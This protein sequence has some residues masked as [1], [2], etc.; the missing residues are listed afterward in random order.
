MSLPNIK[1]PCA[2]CPFRKDTH[3]GWLGGERMEEILQ[4]DS[5]VCHKT[6]GG[7][8][9]DRLQ[10]AGHMILKKEEN[11]FYRMSGRFGIDLNLKGEEL[12]FDTEQDC[13]DYH[14]Q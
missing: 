8:L 12:I 13:I 2:N 11:T 1:K 7:D 10:C 14:D 4:S 9:G 5:F 3:K 6:T